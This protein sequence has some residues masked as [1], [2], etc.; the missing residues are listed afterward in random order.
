MRVKRIELKNFRNYEHLVLDFDQPRTLLIGE[1][2]TGKSTLIDAVAY[3]YLGRC[4]GVDGKGS[5][6][7]DLIRAG[8]DAMQVT[9]WSDELGPVSRGITLAGSSTSSM[10]AEMI[11]GQ[12]RTTEGMLTGVLY[13][14]AFFDMHHSDAT[15]LL[16]KLL[17]VT[18]G[19]DQ[20]PGIDL[21]AGTDAV[22]LP[23]L[24][25]LYDT[26]YQNR[27]A[28]KKTLAAI[29]VPAAP[30]VVAIDLAG[31]TLDD[32]KKQQAAIQTVLRQN[33]QLAARAEVESVQLQQRIQTGERAEGGQAALV[34]HRDAH[35]N[36]LAEH[37]ARLTEAVD[38]LK[39]TEAEPF[40]PVGNLQAQLSETAS[41]SE[42]ISRHILATTGSVP[43]KAKK[44]TTIPVE[45]TTPHSCILGAGIEC[46]TP[47]SDFGAAIDQIK[48]QVKQLEARIH[49]GTQRAGRIAAGQ[50]A[51]KT[52]ERDVAY[53]EGQIKAADDKIAAAKTAAD[54]LPQLRQR[55]QEV[56]QSLTTANG[57]VGEGERAV[58][59]LTDQV[60][61]LAAYDQAVKAHQTGVKKQADMQAQ[62]DESERKV[63]LL[64][65]NGV[66]KTA[67]QTA[68][69]DFEDVINAAL[70][71][72]GFVLRIQA[73]GKGLAIKVQTPM[74]GEA[75]LPYALL[76]DGQKLWTGLA[77]QLALAAVS[78]LDFCIIDGAETVV[79]TNRGL[80]TGLVMGAPVGQVIIAMAKGDHEPAPEL[81]GLQVVR[82]AAVAAAEPAAV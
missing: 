43:T 25:A 78:G 51:V 35:V 21:P 39:A 28:L 19:R 47:A 55:L 54:E 36:M 33:Q 3:A 79:G 66:R 70:D 50:Q 81:D 68:L 7:K 45:D 13:G 74:T 65:P 30:K 23:Y 38:A 2:G 77:F 59:H 72:F 4:R 75:F 31:K 15:A 42:K 34:G 60:G 73:E 64:G 67:L 9:V 80:L 26:E 10:K 61:Q 63:E 37:T 53:H 27:A 46:K 48:A 32:L 14:R 11:L 62:V 57:H 8:A 16:L 82:V 18:V 22:D 41:L 56:H 6:Q 40:E 52:A 44:K 29:S 5:G 20:L 76:S 12:L 69:A 58:A 71:A 49:A 1:N 24:E 17:D